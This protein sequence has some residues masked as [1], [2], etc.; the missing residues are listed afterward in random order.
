MRTLLQPDLSSTRL[1]LVDRPIPI[2]NPDANEHLIRVHCTAPCAGELGWYAYVSLP[3]REPVPCDDMAG[4]VVTAPPN[5]P[6]QPGDEVYARSTFNRPGCARDYTVVVTDE[7]AR[8]PQNLSWAESAAT[9]L[10]AETAWQ[11]LFEQSGIGGFSSSAWKGKRILV[12]A[13]SSST[14]MWLVQL[15]RII[16]AQII[17]TC[18]PN[19]VD[20]VRGL[21]AVDV[22]N[23]RSQSLREWGQNEE[24]K[25]DLVIDCIGG[26]SLEDAWRC[27]R[28]QGIVISICRSP[29]EVKPAEVTAKEVRGLFFIMTPRRS[30]LEEITKLVEAGE[31]RPLVDSVW[32]LEQFQ[33]VFDRVE[34]RHARG[35]V[36]MDL[37]LNRKLES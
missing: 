7:L 36:V 31:C 1:E 22:V 18:G 37:R 30:D 26:Q 15:G 23:Y 2:A 8:R 10:S 21:G 9:P 17:G 6:F 11:A 32:P 29:N 27:V 35:K 24:N 20:L 13:A 5:S 3:D 28:D 14:G 12:T 4:T 34:G 33:S 25:V 16:G 19:N